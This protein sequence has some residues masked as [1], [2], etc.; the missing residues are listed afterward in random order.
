M[1]LIQVAKAL[2]ELTNSPFWSF[3]CDIPVKMEMVLDLR[4]ASVLEDTF[5]QLAATD[6]ESFKKP[7]QVNKTS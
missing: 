6:Q 1:M 3:M 7:L 2:E 5:K 4:R